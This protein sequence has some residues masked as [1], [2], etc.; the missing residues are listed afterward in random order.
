MNIANVEWMKNLKSTGSNIPYY[1]WQGKNFYIKGE[2]N[3]AR[4]DLLR[5]VLPLNF[6]KGKRVVDVGCNLGRM[7]HFAVDMGAA[8]VKGF[9]YDKK[10]SIAANNIVNIEGLQTK[11]NVINQDL[12]SVEIKENFDIAICFSVLHHINPRKH[13]MKFLNNNI[14]ESII[15]EAKNFEAPYNSSYI[16]TE[17]EWDFRDDND[18]ID[19]LRVSIPD[20]KNHKVLGKSER[21]RL[22]ML[23]SKRQI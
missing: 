18:M 4:C 21:N 14:G 6:F 2:R 13:I 7:C 8:S 1:T 11:I 23:F 9:E 5:R 17:T 15:V 3:D 10:T 12:S 19:F 20:F 16:V 22:I